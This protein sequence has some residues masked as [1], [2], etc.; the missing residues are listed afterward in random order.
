[1]RTILTSE[2]AI[3]GPA[4]WHDLKACSAATNLLVVERIRSNKISFYLRYG[5]S[6]APRSIVPSPDT[7][8]A[9]SRSVSITYVPADCGSLLPGKSKAPKAFQ[10]VGIARKL[11]DAG[12]PSVSEYHALDSPAQYSAATFSPAGV[13]NEDLNVSV[14]QRVYRSI[15]KSLTT[16]STTLPPPFQLVLGGECGMLPA[17]LSA[18]WQNAT[19]RSPPLRVGLIYIDADTDLASPEDASFTGNFASVTVTN[20]IRSPGALSSMKQFGTPSGAPVCDASNMV[21]FGTNMPFPGN[22]REHFGYFFDN[23][24]K[25]VSS[26]SVARDPEERA[27]SALKHLEDHAVDVIVVHLDVD[28]IDPVM[29]PLANLPNFTGVGFEQMMRALKVFMGSEK[30]GALMIAEVNPDHDPNLEM[31]TRLTDSVV[32]MLASRHGRE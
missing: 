32:G 2:A 19:S 11:G 14:C 7:S 15:T 10:D 18:F 1:M 24:Y 31:V 20:L 5:R 25:V 23:E 9:A 13:R 26:A 6:R 27:R 22:K 4:K 16:S 3:S 17:I 12:V 29:F 28:A 8:M 30:V 21:L